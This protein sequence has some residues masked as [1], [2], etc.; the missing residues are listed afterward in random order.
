MSQTCLYI[1]PLL[2]ADH[3]RAIRRVGSKE[4]VKNG[5]DSTQTTVH[6]EDGWP[7]PVLGD[8]T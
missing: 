6:V 5:P 7:A 2:I 4:Y 3:P 8:E 1:K